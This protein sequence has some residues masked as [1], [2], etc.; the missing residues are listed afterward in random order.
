M[1]EFIETRSVGGGLKVCDVTTC[2]NV[3]WCHE[4]YHVVGNAMNEYE[5]HDML[6]K[7]TL[8]SRLI[9]FIL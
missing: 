8:S 9:M 7:K 4:V 2:I 1:A 6:C 5:I 3:V